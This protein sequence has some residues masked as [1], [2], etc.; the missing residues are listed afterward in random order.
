MM[1]E[2]L[3]GGV[4][5]NIGFQKGTIANPKGKPKG[6]TFTTIMRE[7]ADELGDGEPKGGKTKKQ[8]IIEKLLV[9]AV[10]GE[11]WAVECVLDRMDG[12]AV[13]VQQIDVT[14]G[15]QSLNAAVSFCKVGEVPVE[16]DEVKTVDA[17]PVVES[18]EPTLPVRNKIQW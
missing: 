16:I 15:G 7:M 9:K 2:E 18:E 17:L 3:N 4:K 13:N 12:K 6:R 11:R 8:L 14:S 5:N 1:S 10:R